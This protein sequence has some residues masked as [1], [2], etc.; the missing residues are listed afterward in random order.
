M[1][2]TTVRPIAAAP[3]RASASL[4]L[5]RASPTARSVCRSRW[6]ALPLYVHL[7]KFYGE[8]HLAWAS[9]RSARCCWCLRLADAVDR[10]VA[11]RVERSRAVA[12]ALIA[13]GR[14]GRSRS[15]CVALFMP[16]VR[17]EG[18]LLAWLGVALALVYVA[19][20]LAT[21]NHNAWGAELSSDPVER[22]RIT[23]MREGIG[24]RRRR[25][26][27]RRAGHA[28]RRGRRGRRACRG[29]RWAP[30]R[31][32]A[33]RS[34]SPSPAPAAPRGARPPADAPFAGIAEALADPLFRRLARRVHG[35]R[36]RVGDSGDAGAVLRRRRPAGRRPPGDVPRDSIS[37]RARPACRC[38]C[39]CRRASARYGAWHA[40]MVVA[41]VAFV[42]AARLGPGDVVRVR[43]HL[44]VSG[45]AL[46]ADL[47]LPPSLLADVIGRSGRMRRDRLVLRR[48]DARHEAQS[49]ARRR[50]RAAAARGAGLHSRSPAKPPRLTRAG[51]RLRRGAVALKLGAAGAL[52]WFDRCGDD[53]EDDPPTAPG[54]RHSC[55]GIVRQRRRNAVVQETLTWASSRRSIRRCRPGPTRA[56]GSIGASTGIGAATATAAARTRRARRAVGASADKLADVA[57]ARRRAGPRDR[58]AARLHRRG[59][60]SPPRGSACAPHWGGCDLVLIVAGTH[61]EDPRVGTQR[62]G[63]ARALFE[64]NL[65]GRS[66]HDA[67]V[68]PALLAQGQRRDRHRG[69]GG[70]LPRAAEGAGLWRVEGRADQLHRDALPRPPL[71]EASAS[72]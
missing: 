67:A 33:V 22:T 17:G 72:T 63:R 8:G 12:Q 36:H 42:W 1:T 71:R 6:R 59:A 15:A 9:R 32:R 20:S 5:R 37:S 28:R 60:R 54:P 34:R 65:H 35:E 3:A 43:D 40:G 7:P 66:G 23:A 47:A 21:I 2:T 25:H 48:V 38:G 19:F 30:S 4:S 52:F 68:V 45:L 46:G 39:G 44:R 58:R 14:A 64:V 29:S 41:I 51:D 57:G 53:D 27:E 69:V 26:R 10:S 13:C 61:D 50:H 62:E 24:T 18:A 31:V 55:A 56:S 49:R 16:P 11:R 70:G